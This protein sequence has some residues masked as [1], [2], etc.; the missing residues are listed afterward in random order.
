MATTTAL[1]KAI[2]HED[3]GRQVVLEGEEVL[4]ALFVHFIEYCVTITKMAFSS[5]LHPPML[6]GGGS[7]DGE[8]PFLRLLLSPLE[9]FIAS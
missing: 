1:E 2:H 8:W 5:L 3:F 7:L 4:S 6:L 9:Q